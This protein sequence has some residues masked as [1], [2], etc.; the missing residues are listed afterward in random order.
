MANFL[1]MFWKYFSCFFGF[2]FPIWFCL[3]LAIGGAIA[4]KIEERRH[5][6]EENL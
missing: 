2:A 6:D 1:E 3:F 5:P 4:I